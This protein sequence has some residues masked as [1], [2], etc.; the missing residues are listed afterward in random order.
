MNTLYRA[1][2]KIESSSWDGNEAIDYI[3]TKDGGKMSV[4]T[5]HGE[6][7][8]EKD[9]FKIEWDLQ[10]LPL[11][12][13]SEEDIKYFKKNELKEK[14]IE[15]DLEKEISEVDLDGDISFPIEEKTS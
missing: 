3:Y 12:E 5:P 13:A 9:G 8:I 11:N 14:V 4:K 10:E 6:K 1:I 7:W 15:E 2:G